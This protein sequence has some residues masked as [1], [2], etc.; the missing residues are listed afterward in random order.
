MRWPT[1]MTAPGSVKDDSQ[2][3]TVTADAE[4]LPPAIAGSAD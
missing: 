3:A 1:R 4:R 2:K